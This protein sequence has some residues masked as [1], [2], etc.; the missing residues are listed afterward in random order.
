MSGYL[1]RGSPWLEE[2]NAAIM[3]TRPERPQAGPHGAAKYQRGCRCPVC[4][5]AKS[6]ENAKT[7]ARRTAA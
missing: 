4:R 1:Y 7:N 3:A 5:A 6:R 2:A